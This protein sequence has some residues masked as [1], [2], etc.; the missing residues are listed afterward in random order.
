[1]GFLRFFAFAGDA[2]R[3]NLRATEVSTELGLSLALNP[4]AIK[5]EL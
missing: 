2:Q 3:R 4:Y 1:M 5:W